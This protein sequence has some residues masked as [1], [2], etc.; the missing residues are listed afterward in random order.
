M[1]PLSSIIIPVYNVAPYLYE[2][3]SMVPVTAT[4][5]RLR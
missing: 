5:I 4:K 1:T 3:I 2:H